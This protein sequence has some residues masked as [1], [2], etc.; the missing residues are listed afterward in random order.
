[1]L[2]F[3]KHS[4]QADART[5]AFLALKAIQNGGFANV[6]VDDVLTQSPLPDRDRRLVA[7]LVYGSVRRQR[8]LDT[9]IDQLASK[10]ASDQPPDLR[11]I[12]H[13][14]LYQLRYLTHIPASAAVNTTVDLAKQQRLGG[15]SGFVNGL[16]RR[17]TRL[18]ETG[19]DPLQ[20][21]EAAIARLGVQHSYPDWIVQV[22]MDQLGLAAAETLCDWLNQPPSLDLRVNRLRASVDIVLQEFQQ[23]GLEAE[24]VPHL[25]DGIRLRGGAVRSLPGFQEGLWT[26]QD[27]SA[28]LVSHCLDPQPGEVVIDACAAPGGKTTHIAE[29]MGDRGTV[30]GCDRYASRLK[31]IDQTAQRLGLT[32]IQT[33]LGD[34]TQME[35]FIGQGD[36]VLVDAPCSGLG[37][38]HRHADARW[39]QTP[40][41]VEALVLLQ[42]Q[43]LTQAATWVKPGGY[44]V[45]ST[46]TLHPAENQG[47]VQQFLANHPHWQLQSLSSMAIA[48]PYDSSE[49][50]L[51]VWP[52]KHHMDGFFM[53]K[54]QRSPE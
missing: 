9:L 34:S 47:V 46:C 45:Y 16:L 5:L 35:Q 36:R 4:Q 17:Y 3:M 30:W 42:Q 43:L 21:P 33:C 10:P 6:I 7:E 54:L 2:D 1:M 14:G 29:L 15:L 49:G 23:A 25:P 38:L 12:L 26:V 53:A 44:L 39:R 11:L 20:L 50:W 48:T 22:Y 41:S 27:S 24:P 52:H 37:T 19:V 31:R 13:L 8:T 51:T 18:A 28:Q 32:S 40:E